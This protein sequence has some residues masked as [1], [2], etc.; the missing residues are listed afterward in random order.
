[1]ICVHCIANSGVKVRKAFHHSLIDDSYNSYKS[2][3][4]CFKNNIYIILTVVVVGTDEPYECPQGTFRGSKL[5]QMESDCSNCTGGWYCNGTGRTSE[6]GECDPGYYCPSKSVSK[7]ERECPQGYYCPKGTEYP[8]KCPSGH[9]SNNTGLHNSS[10]CSPCTPGFYCLTSG[11]TSP[12][13][14]CTAGY[15]CPEGSIIDT[16]KPCSSAMHCPTGSSEP[17]FCIQG[18]Y[19]DGPLRGD[20]LTCP[21]GSYCVPDTVVKGIS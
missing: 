1:M 2:S 8:K 18:N 13:G 21:P 19:S 11:L 9:F 12:T 17:K 20:C 15:Y 4:C 3:G 16:A 5:G 14:Q 7:T 10:Q 6:A